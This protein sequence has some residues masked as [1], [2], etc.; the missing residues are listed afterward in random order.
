M[1]KKKSPR[2]FYA[3]GSMLRLMR[4]V[5]FDAN[6]C[7]MFNWTHLSY[8]Q[9]GRAYQQAGRAYQQAGRRANQSMNRIK[10]NNLEQNLKK[11]KIKTHR[12]L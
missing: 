4:R 9:A 6:Q 1:R 11:S 5:A 12:S 8:R 3:E 7:S 10:N 2:R